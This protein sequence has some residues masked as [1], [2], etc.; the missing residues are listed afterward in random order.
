MS[1]NAFEQLVYTKRGKVV[2][3]LLNRPDVLNALSI[4]LYTELGEAV[5]RANADPD[6]RV[7]VITGAGRAFSTGGDL[8]QGSTVNR[9]APQLFAK[10][11]NSAIRQIMDAE[12]IVV[13]KINGITQ[14]GGLLIVA[15]SDLAIASDRATFKCPEALVGLWEPYS[16]E[17]LTPQMGVKRTKYLLLT[18]D[19]IDAAEAERSG[20][21]N[22]VVPHEELDGATEKM[23]ERVLAG[24]PM[25]LRNF[26][27]MIN[28]RFGDFDTDIV[29][30]ALGSEEGLEG[31][32][33]FA[34][35]RKPRWRE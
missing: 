22:R 28:E 32:A 33:A 31:M 35:K 11:S 13:A 18:S 30:D 6:V 34:E 21:I 19:T 29:I 17:L 23:I 15:A 7:I 3:I 20:L 2:E 1:E 27:R 26:K 16:P 25:A 4:R 8:K 12:K 24:G 10:A 5:A 9:E 14:A